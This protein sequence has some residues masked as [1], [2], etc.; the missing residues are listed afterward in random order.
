[1]P[2]IENITNDRQF[3]TATS[4][5]KKTFYLLLSDFSLEYKEQNGRSYENYLSETLLP[6]ESAKLQLFSV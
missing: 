4:Y 5:D 2:I 3:K 6:H 1:M